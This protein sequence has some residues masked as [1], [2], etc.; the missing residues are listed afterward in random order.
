MKAFLVGLL[1]IIAV[2]FLSVLGVFLYPFL[3]LLTFV[4]RI[5]IGMAL[6]VFAVWL[7]GKLIIFIWELLSGKQQ[8]TRGKS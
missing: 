3:L 6:V 5:I 7:L 4:L 8:I 1:F 2:S